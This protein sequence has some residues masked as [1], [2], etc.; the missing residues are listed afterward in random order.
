MEFSKREVVADGKPSPALDIESFRG[1]ENTLNCITR[2]AQTFRKTGKNQEWHPFTVIAL[3]KAILD[4][5][6]H[7]TE[8]IHEIAANEAVY[9]PSFFRHCDPG[10]K[11]GGL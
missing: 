8:L 2:L 4:G 9:Y 3:A 6:A 7:V 11:L 1:S 10:W 5:E